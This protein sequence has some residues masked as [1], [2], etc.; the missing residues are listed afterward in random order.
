MLSE[1]P[2]TGS[3]VV[4]D[5]TFPHREAAGGWQVPRRTAGVDASSQGPRWRR[6][7]DLR[8]EQQGMDGAHS[9]GGRREAQEWASLLC[10]PAKPCKPEDF[11]HESTLL[12]RDHD[13]SASSVESLGCTWGGLVG[14]TT[15][16]RATRGTPPTPHRM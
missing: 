10:S 9:D 2:Y 3:V 16:Q 8:W 15:V 4:S 13:G 11:D 7:A 5:W 12:P 6:P 1:Q 14:H